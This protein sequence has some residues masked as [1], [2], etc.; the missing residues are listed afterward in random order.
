M[1]TTL[2]SIKVVYEQVVE[3][4]MLCGFDDDLAA[5]ITQVSNLIRGLLTQIYPTPDRVIEPRP[6]YPAIP[7]VL[8]RYPLPAIL[9]EA[10]KKRV[11]TRLLKRACRGGRRCLTCST[12]RPVTVVGTDAATTVMPCLA[13]QLLELRTQCG[14]IAVEAERIVD[15][16][17]PHSVLTG[18]PRVGVRTSVRLLMEITRKR[19]PRAGHLTAYA[20]L[21]PITWQ[22]GSSI[23]DEYPSKRGHKILKRAMYLSA[24]ATLR[25][26]ESRAYYDREIAQG[27][28]H[29]QA[30]IALACRYDVLD[31]IL[32]ASSRYQARRPIETALAA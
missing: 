1:S 7:D 31:A 24:F 6:D 19:F 4:S 27:R 14:E 18:I 20:G 30:V 13:K 8:E 12:S 29:N 3:L 32:C 5:Q 2:R 23:H 11:G 15:A 21:A 25:T 26:P 22:S 9:R 28:R 16:Y 17:P 10:G